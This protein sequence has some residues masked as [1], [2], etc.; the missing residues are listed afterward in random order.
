MN[1]TAIKKMFKTA[2]RPAATDEIAEDHEAIARQVIEDIS[3]GG[4]LATTRAASGSGTARASSSSR[5]ARST[6]TSPSG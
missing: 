2:A 3:R 1:R 5:T 4:E 6:G